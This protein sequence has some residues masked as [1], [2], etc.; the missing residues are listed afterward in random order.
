MGH[1]QT[2][3]H[4]AKQLCPTPTQQTYLLPGIEFG[5]LP[6]ILVLVVLQIVANLTQ[7]EVVTPLVGAL[8]ISP[9][10]LQPDLFL[11][12]K[13]VGVPDLVLAVG[14]L[15]HGK[16]VAVHGSI[17]GAAIDLDLDGTTG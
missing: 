15:G 13:R 8:A 2:F 6:Q 12:R 7:F 4:Q 10:G 3:R 5:T 9:G 11:D 16:I 14:F 17:G 1:C